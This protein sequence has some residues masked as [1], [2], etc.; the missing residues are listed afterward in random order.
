MFLVQKPVEQNPALSQSS[1]VTIK[2]IFWDKHQKEKYCRQCPLPPNHYLPTPLSFATM[3]S[4]C[5]GHPRVGGH[6]KVKPSAASNYDFAL[7]NCAH[8]KGIGALAFDLLMLHP[9]EYSWA[10][11]FHKSQKVD[12]TVQAKCKLDKLHIAFLGLT[13]ASRWK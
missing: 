1:G 3:L 4:R 11:V 13:Q 9:S 5:P 2:W 10:I 7:S 12:S 8:Q 6:L